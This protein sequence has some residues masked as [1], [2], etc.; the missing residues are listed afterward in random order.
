MNIKDD[1]GNTVLSLTVNAGG[2]LEG[3]NGLKTSDGRAVEIV[4]SGPDSDGVVTWQ[5]VVA[6][7][8]EGAGDPVFTF[9]LDTAGADQGEFDFCLHQA[10]E[11][12]D[13]NND[14]SDDETDDGTEFVRRQPARRLHGARL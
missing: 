4:R 6:A 3:A 12:P 14:P 13:S 2:D 8:E 5:A 9:N 1:G 10:I 11:H 7:G